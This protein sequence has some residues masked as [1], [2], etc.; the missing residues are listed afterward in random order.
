MSI[1][2]AL[3]AVSGWLC[4]GILAVP[5]L[6]ER[7][8]RE[9]YERTREGQLEANLRDAVHYI[10]HMPETEDPALIVRQAK[11]VIEAKY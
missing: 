7:M 10:E 2:V 5:L 6:I 1:A 9:P 8:N 3:V 4:L 11:R